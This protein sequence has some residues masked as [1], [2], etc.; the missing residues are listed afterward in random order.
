[1]PILFFL[2]GAALFTA[3]YAATQSAAPPWIAPDSPSPAPAP[4]PS[5]SPAPSPAGGP[6]LVE[7]PV[8]A[9]AFL[10]SGVQ[11][12]ALVQLTGLE[13]IFGTKS[14]VE[15]KLKDLGFVS[16]FVWTK[17][18]AIPAYFPVRAP[19]TGNGT[20]YWVQGLNQGASGVQAWPSQI[21]RA[22]VNRGA[23]ATPSTS[24]SLSHAQGIYRSPWG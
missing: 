3:I 7:I 2:G 18:E 22:W 8:S 23:S 20:Y 19:P 16:V 14:A 21:V 4:P 12:L 10:E 6:Q 5:P 17:D 24:G 1:M 15:S 9:H 13:S 11:Y